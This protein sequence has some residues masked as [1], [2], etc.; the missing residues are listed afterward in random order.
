MPDTVL[1]KSFIDNTIAVD[2][3]LKKATNGNTPPVEI[4]VDELKNAATAGK[5][6]KDSLVWD[7][8]SKTWKASTV[9]STQGPQGKFRVLVFNAVAHCDA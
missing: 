2:P 7:E 8:P 1:R 6:D 4:E 3:E 9:L 5:R